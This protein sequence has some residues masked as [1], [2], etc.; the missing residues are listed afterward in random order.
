MKHHAAS[1]L[2]VTCS[3]ELRAACRALLAGVAA[4][5][6]W[7]ALAPLAEAAERYDTPLDVVASCVLGPTCA[8][9][10]MPIEE[11]GVDEPIG[12]VHGKPK[13]VQIALF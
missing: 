6:A 4:A 9:C 12:W 3:P 8:R 1:V 13:P 7:A 5:E 2:G 11:G 10:G